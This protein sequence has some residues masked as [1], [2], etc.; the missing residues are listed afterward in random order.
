MNS[1]ILCVIAREQSDRSN[2][3]VGRATGRVGVQ[4]TVDAGSIGEKL[5]GILEFIMMR[6]SGQARG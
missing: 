1:R 5:S 4:I 2:L 3:S 6:S